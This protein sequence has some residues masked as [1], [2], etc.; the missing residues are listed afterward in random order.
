MH[1]ENGYIADI[2]TDRP[3]DRTAAGVG[4]GSTFAEVKRA[5]RAHHL[6]AGTDTYDEDVPQ[7]RVDPLAFELRRLGPVPHQGD[8]PV[9]ISI[10][11][12]F[13]RGP[14]QDKS[15]V[16]RVSIGSHPIESCA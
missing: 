8:D 2:A 16:V 11:F 13:G 15:R 5:F 4:A 14:L 12:T 6:V 3:V 10:E 7:V 1:F 9:S